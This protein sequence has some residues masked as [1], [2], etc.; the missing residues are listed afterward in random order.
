MMLDG[1]RGLCHDLDVPS[2]KL[3]GKLSIQP[4]S[5]DRER[6]L[7]LLHDHRH[8]VLGSVQN[9]FVNC[10]RLQRVRDK[11]LQRLMPAD[12]INSLSFQL[13]DD[14]FDAAASLSYARSDAIHLGIMAVDGNLGP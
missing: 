10:G 9:D 1:I 4:F 5:T 7:A 12:Q 2:T 11:L 3:T 14:S 13:I 6:Q 8:P